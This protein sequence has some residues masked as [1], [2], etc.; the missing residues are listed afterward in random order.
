MSGAQKPT[1]VNAGAGGAPAGSCVQP[2]PLKDKIEGTPAA[3]DAGAN[4]I[5]CRGETLVVQNNNTG[6]DK[7][8]TQAHENSHIADWKGRYGDDLCKG[9]PD[10]QLPLGG[11]GYDEFLRQS[12][13]KAYKIGKACRQKLLETASDADKPAIQRAIVRDDA[14]I[15]ANRCT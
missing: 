5:V 9:V 13:C 2:C 7:D 15:A 10:G 8:C 11:D 14:Q 3:I 1:P 6:P 12:E 4:S